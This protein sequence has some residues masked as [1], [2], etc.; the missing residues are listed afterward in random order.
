MYNIQ[1]PPRPTHYALENGKFWD[2]AAASY[3]QTLPKDA[4][5]VKAPG[6]DGKC[7]E[8]GL[9]AALK[10]YGYEQGAL[11]SSEDKTADIKAQLADIDAQSARPA[12]AIALAV[13][14]GATPEHADIAKLESLEE[15][16]ISLRAEL[17][18]LGS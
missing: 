18:A 16:A 11:K 5:A 3:I 15:Q 9:I 13:V 6:P 10:F 2:I 14:K 12:R 7:D 1:Q 8:A 17:A 4:K